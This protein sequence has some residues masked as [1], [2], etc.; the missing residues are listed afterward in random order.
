MLICFDILYPEVWH[1]A[2]AAGAE[3]VVWPT[4][5]NTPAPF[6]HAYAQLHHYYI[7]ACGH[8]GEVVDITGGS[9]P[10]RRLDGWPRM[11][12]AVA[13]L[14]RVSV[15]W[16]RNHKLV[17]RLLQ[18]HAGDVVAGKAWVAVVSWRQCHP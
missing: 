18:E 4:A 17:P 2:E 14:D 12:V 6:A 3:L 13:D 1:A 11:Q 16:W 9:V 10:G 15:S 5:M 7:A 8:P